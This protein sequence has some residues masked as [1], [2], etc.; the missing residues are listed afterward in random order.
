MGITWMFRGP[1]GAGATLG[2]VIFKLS[3][4]QQHHLV[5][6][7]RGSESLGCVR[8]CHHTGSPVHGILQARILEW[9]AIPFSRGSSRPRD[10]T[11]VSLTAGRF[12][13]V[14]ATRPGGGTEKNSQPPHHLGRETE[15]A[16]F[17]VV[18]W[19]SHLFQSRL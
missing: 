1:S 19:H 5:A 6:S 17:L 13:I 12:F 15:R 9:V 4:G 16:W 10:E 14:L 18:S 7:S 3:A 11:W 2:Q 8:P